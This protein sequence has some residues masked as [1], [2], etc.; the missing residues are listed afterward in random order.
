MEMHQ[1]RYFLALCETLN[2]T[3]A[4]ERCNVAQPSLTRAIR[5]LEDELGGPL[6]NRERNNTHQTELGRMMEPHLREVMAQAQTARARASAFFELRTA[7][8]KLGLSRGVALP[9]VAEPLQ[10]F[11]CA[12][13]DTE[14]ILVDDHATGLR[15]A[16]RGGDLEVVVLPQHPVDIDDLHYYPVGDD[17]LQVLMR[18]DHRFAAGEGVPLRELLDEALIAREGCLFV[19]AIERYL[20]EEGLTIRPRITAGS[21]EW[22]PTLVERGFGVAVTGIHFGVPPGLVGRPVVE[23]PSPRDVSL[24]TKRGRLY[25]P[26]VKAFVD[27]ALRPA[28][29]IPD[30]EVA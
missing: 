17:R 13:P 25:S 24:A 12:H 9:L 19:E 20:I 7:R 26:P 28:R 6:F 2:F 16:L 22:L 11:A 4:A 29:S 10:R 15:E 5:L 1:V 8:L 23:L 21:T 14:I 27:M 30:A 3:R 18:P